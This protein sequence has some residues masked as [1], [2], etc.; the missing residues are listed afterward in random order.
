M[1]KNIVY[2][3]ASNFTNNI[4][5]YHYRTIVMASGNLISVGIFTK[6]GFFNERMFIDYVDNEF[7][8]RCHINKLQILEADDA[9]LK[10]N[11]GNIGVHFFMGKR[12]ITTN[13]NHIRRYY[14]ARNRVYV[15]KKYIKIF[16]KWV[17]SDVKSFIKEIIG[18]IFF[19]KDKMKKIILIIKGIND[20]LKNRL[21]KIQY[22]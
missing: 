12:L 22:R 4:L 11:L 19:E 8:I 18:I 10:H 5:K 13:H 14:N 21:G 20:G 7:C 1:E 15:Y 3:D 9:I 16:P 17:L 6:V 2:S